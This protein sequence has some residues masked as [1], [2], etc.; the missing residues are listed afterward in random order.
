MAEVHARIGPLEAS[1]GSAPATGDVVTLVVEAVD[2]THD[3]PDD[4]RFGVL[5]ADGERWIAALDGRYLS[6]EVAGGFTGRTLGLRAL[7]ATPARVVS[8]RYVPLGDE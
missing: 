1:A 6:T 4:L 3:G 5:D 2:A 7:G 8:V